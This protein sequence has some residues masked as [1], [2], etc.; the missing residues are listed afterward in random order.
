MDLVTE[1]CQGLESSAV[2]TAPLFLVE[3]LPGRSN[4]SLPR[5]PLHMHAQVIILTFLMWN[6]DIGICHPKALTLTQLR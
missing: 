4:M 1:Y 2:Y 6:I 5:L 3:T